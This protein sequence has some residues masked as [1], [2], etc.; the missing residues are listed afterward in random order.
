MIS[1]QDFHATSHF[2]CRRRLR[3]LVQ[4][5]IWAH[6]ISTVGKRIRGRLKFIGSSNGPKKSRGDTEDRLM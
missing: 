5:R 2:Q 4:T 6:T 1:I 3:R